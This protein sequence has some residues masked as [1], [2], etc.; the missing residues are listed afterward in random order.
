MCVCVWLPEGVLA[1][2]SDKS[3]FP[4][5]YGSALKC[6][7][8]ARVWNTQSPANATLKDRGLAGRSRSVGDMNA[9]SVYIHTHTHIYINIHTHTHSHAHTLVHV[10]TLIH[11]SITT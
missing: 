6:P 8:Q 7:L 10:Y 4:H 9:F 11:T 3:P 2:P 1:K 5:C